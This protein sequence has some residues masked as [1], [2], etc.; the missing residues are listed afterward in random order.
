MK[1]IWLRPLGL[2][3]LLLALAAPVRG[4]SFGFPWW[5][6][7]QFQ[8]ELALTAEQRTRI[9]AIFQDALTKLRQKNQELNQQEDELSRMIAS[10]ADE[11]VIVKQVDKVEGV[12]AHLNKTR[13]L[14]L[15]HERQVLTPDQRLKLNKLHEQW[16]K[17]HPT[18]PNNRP[19][20]DVK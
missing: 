20:G 13:T 11:S 12:R 2:A 3:A 17:D 7:A 14:M 16:V 5:R 19:R 15:L 1:P 9:D 18:T 8:R 6:D 10:N 4:Q